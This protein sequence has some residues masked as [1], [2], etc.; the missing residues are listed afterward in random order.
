M[1]R[2]IEQLLKFHINQIFF[3]V[4]ALVTVDYDYG[5]FPNVGPYFRVDEL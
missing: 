1:S 3:Q 4:I 2:K 5:R